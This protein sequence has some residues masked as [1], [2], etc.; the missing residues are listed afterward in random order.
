MDK[1]GA[2]SLLHFLGVFGIHSGAAFAA[3]IGPLAEVSV[4]IEVVNVTLWFHKRY[5]N[6]T[7]NTKGE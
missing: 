6:N 4:M 7:N 1:Q 2:T 5:F 3:I